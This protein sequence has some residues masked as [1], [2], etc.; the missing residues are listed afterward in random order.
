MTANPQEA[1]LL[2]LRAERDRLAARV[3]ELRQLVGDV[4]DRL[5]RGDSD[6]ELLA[7]LEAGWGP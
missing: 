3:S 7:M 1:E 6:A 2:A 5:L 4:H